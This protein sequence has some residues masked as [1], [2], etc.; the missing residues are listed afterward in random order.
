MYWGSVFSCLVSDWK[1]MPSHLTAETQPETSRNFMQLFQQ[2][3]L[4]RSRHLLPTTLAILWCLG[5]AVKCSCEDEG[6]LFP[7]TVF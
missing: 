7:P 2:T 6:G 5:E 3:P 1:S 4:R